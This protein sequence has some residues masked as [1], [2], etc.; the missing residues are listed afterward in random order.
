M[1]YRIKGTDKDGHYYYSPVRAV[2]AENISGRFTLYPNPVQNSF[3]L[4]GDSPENIREIQLFNAGGILLRIWKGAQSGYNIASLP[5]SAYSI[6]IA[7]KDD[8]I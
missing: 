3:N 4:T 8:T 2:G 7:K 1:F 6:R 5:A